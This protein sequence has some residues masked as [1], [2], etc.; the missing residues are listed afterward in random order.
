MHKI[1]QRI[2][3]GAG[4]ICDLDLVAELTE[5]L[6]M[7]PGLSIC[8]LSDGAAWPLRLI[9]NKFR[10]EFEER[11]AAQE[12]SATRRRIKQINPAAYELPIAGGRIESY[13]GGTYYE[14]SAKPAR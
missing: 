4:R 9:V 14:P 2:R 3:D 12:P 1:A 10:R 5:N 8:G 7:M 11:I 6:G 13:S